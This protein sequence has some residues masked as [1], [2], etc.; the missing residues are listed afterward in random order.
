M[1]DPN[2]VP[3]I[4]GVLSVIVSIAAFVL[5]DSEKNK[6]WRVGLGIAF[7]FLAIILG[8]YGV[9]VLMLPRDAGRSIGET[10]I[11]MK[12]TALP[13][14]TSIPPLLTPKAADLSHYADLPITLSGCGSALEPG[15]T[16][17]VESGT[18][19]MGDIIIDGMRQF[20]GRTGE[21]TVA[22]FERD[23]IV[24]ANWGAGCYLGDISLLDEVVQGEFLHGCG[25]TCSK[26]R[27]VIMYDDGTQV[28][29]C[30]YLGGPVQPLQK[31]GTE[32]WCP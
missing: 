25:S 5:G 3:L 27:V 29:E 12:P 23:A 2:F 8:T 11:V 26:V 20:D 7:L 21:G 16:R 1:N 9:V 19:I 15:E 22:Y 14:T 32:T 6:P 28:A 24:Q 31:S 13:T 30:R 10:E 17:S 4:L 18:F